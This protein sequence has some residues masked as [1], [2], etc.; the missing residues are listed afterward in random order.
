MYFL[1]FPKVEKKQSHYKGF[2]LAE[3]KHLRVS[4][5]WHTQKALLTWSPVTCSSKPDTTIYFV[6]FPQGP[7]ANNRTPSFLLKSTSHFSPILGKEFPTQNLLES[8]ANS[9]QS[10]AFIL[11]EMSFN[12]TIKEHLGKNYFSNFLKECSVKSNYLFL[13]MWFISSPHL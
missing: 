4:K 6:T 9:R 5:E 11:S 13:G 2:F 8:M 12:F 1:V 7:A 10:K 3:G